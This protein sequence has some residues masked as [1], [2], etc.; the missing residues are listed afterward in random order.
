MINKG[1]RAKSTE[2]TYLSGGYINIEKDATT[3]SRK[4]IRKEI[5]LGVTHRV[6]VWPI[7]LVGIPSKT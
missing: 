6:V 1:K 3:K 7:L 2:C 4:Q 5:S